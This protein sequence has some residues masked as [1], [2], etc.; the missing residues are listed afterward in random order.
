MFPAWL[1]P[2]GPRLFHCSTCLFQTL[3]FHREPR[4]KEGQK[5]MFFAQSF[6]SNKINLK[7]LLNPSRSVVSE[8]EREKNPLTKFDFYLEDGNFV[9]GRRKK[10]LKVKRERQSIKLIQK[11]KERKKK[12][13]EE[14]E[15]KKAEDRER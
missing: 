5:G 10:R 7:T 2:F 8:E 14:E 13:K 3:D 6:E 15:E 12:K 1:S 4:K 9:P 11:K